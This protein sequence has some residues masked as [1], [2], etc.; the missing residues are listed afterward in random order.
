MYLTV[1]TLKCFIFISNCA[2]MPLMAACRASPRLTEGDGLKRRSVN[3]PI[4]R[5]AYVNAAVKLHKL[6][7]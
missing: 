4:A 5:S 3:P 2:R 6:G 1:N 7:H